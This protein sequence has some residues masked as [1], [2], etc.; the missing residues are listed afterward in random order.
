MLWHGLQRF[1]RQWVPFHFYVRRGQL[2][3]IVIK[4]VRPSLQIA[5]TNHAQNIV[6]ETDRF[7]PFCLKASFWCHFQEKES[8]ERGLV[9]E[10]WTVKWTAELIQLDDVKQKRQP[11][12]PRFLGGRG[13]CEGPGRW[14]SKAETRNW[15]SKLFFFPFPTS[16]SLPQVDHQSTTSVCT[17][18][19]HFRGLVASRH[20]P[21]C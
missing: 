15:I 20:L 11:Q 2:A 1:R 8:E 19:K 14:G 18:T 3:Y 10:R 13:A 16:G 21:F 12:I 9:R 17:L 5:D 4:I 7:S 6:H